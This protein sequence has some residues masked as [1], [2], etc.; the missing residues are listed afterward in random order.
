MV[1]FDGGLRGTAHGQHPRVAWVWRTRRAE[2][3]GGNKRR[4]RGGRCG[5]ARAASRGVTAAA[6]RLAAQLPTFHERRGRAGAGAR[7]RGVCRPAAGVRVQAA[8]KGVQ[9][10]GRGHRRGARDSPRAAPDA[11]RGARAAGSDDPT[12]LPRHVLVPAVLRAHRR[13]VR[14]RRTA[15]QRQSDAVPCG[16]S[17]RGELCDLGSRVADP[18]GLDAMRPLQATSSSDCAPTSSMRWPRRDRER[19][20]ARRGHARRSVRGRPGRRAHARRSASRRSAATAR[21]FSVVGV[22]L[23]SARAM[24]STAWTHPRRTRGATLGRG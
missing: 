15:H 21:A 2:R 9:R 20:N 3:R 14:R 13:A 24:W 19:L 8:A 17:F 16:D 5:R 23:T 1:A 18:R 4:A 12:L 7:R 10:H 22:L 11:R 6:G